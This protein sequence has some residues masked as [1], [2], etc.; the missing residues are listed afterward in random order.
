VINCNTKVGDF[1]W[2]D[3]DQDGVQGANEAGIS[4]VTVQLYNSANVLVDTKTT[5]IFGEYLFEYVLPGTYY[6][7]FSNLP[8]G[9]IFTTQNTGTANGSDAASTG[10]TSNFT[11]TASVDNYTID[12]GAY[13]GYG[14]IGNYVW[15]DANH[16]GLQNGEAGIAGVEVR[17]CDAFGTLL[18]ST[19]TDANGYYNFAVLPGT[20]SVSFYRSGWTLTAQN[21]NTTTGSDPAINTGKTANFTVVAGQNRTDIDAGFVVCA[22]GKTAAPNNG[23]ARQSANNGTASNG[24]SVSRNSVSLY[25]NPVA[26]SDL[27]VKVT[28]Q[29][30][31][32]NA[33][34]VVLDITGKM[35]FTQQTN[36][37]EGTNYVRLDVTSL[38][39]GTY[40]VQ[41]RSS[42][43]QFETQKFVRIK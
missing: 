20:Y 4:G 38:A 10:I 19:I 23:A 16:D 14:N 6:V 35:M 5:D 33:T 29:T 8:T 22:C 3:A 18:Q 30:Q 2:H 25:P 39:E 31:D 41:V 21:Q 42:I 36:L 32:L 7:K 17:L 27:N 13:L 40:L 28:T 34:I 9:Y 37:S 43:A 12:A 15:Y 1:V 11:V 26:A 24:F